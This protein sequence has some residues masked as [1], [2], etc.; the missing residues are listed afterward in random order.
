MDGH[1]KAQ[2]YHAGNSSPLRTYSPKRGAI[3]GA[4]TS[5]YNVTQVKAQTQYVHAAGSSLE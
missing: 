2:T 5:S 3:D 4:A 1:N